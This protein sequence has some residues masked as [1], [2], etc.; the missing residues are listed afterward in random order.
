[1][2]YAVGY[3]ALP[4]S[5]RCPP[6]R[7]RRDAREGGD[8]SWGSPP[9]PSC[10]P[11]VLRGVGRPSLAV[12][13]AASLLLRS[14]LDVVARRGQRPWPL[15]RQSCSPPSATGVMRSATEDG[16]VHG[17][18]WSWH[19][20]SHAHAGWR[21]RMRTRSA[22]GGG[23][24][25]LARQDASIAFAQDLGLVVEV[26]PQHRELLRRPIASAGPCVEGR[27]LPLPVVVSAVRPTSLPGLEACDSGSDASHRDR[28]LLRPHAPCA[29]SGNNE[30]RRA[31]SHDG[32]TRGTHPT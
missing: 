21:R 8:G 32:S 16:W 22:A 29:P 12:A 14:G 20:P 28:E 31:R 11:G 4:A 1:M 23:E 7:C 27:L 18:S 30:T 6:R 10:E 25:R 13:D 15:P 5:Q 3:G 26:I 24:G 9:T 17:P 2:G 19:Q